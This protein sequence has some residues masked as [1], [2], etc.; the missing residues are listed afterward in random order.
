MNKVSKC[1][2]MLSGILMLVG[3]AEATQ[4]LDRG[5]GAEVTT[6]NQRGTLLEFEKIG[7]MTRKEIAASLVEAKIPGVPGQGVT[8]FRVSYAT[9][10][11]MG[12]ATIASG[13]IA[14]PEKLDDPAPILSFHHGTVVARN[15]VPS[16]QGFDLVSMGLGASGYITLLPDYL[17]LGIDTGFHPYVHAKSSGTVV[18]DMIRAASAFLDAHEVQTNGQLFLMGYSEGGYVTMAA[19]RE[20]E[21]YHED[22]IT[23]TASAP[24]A[25]PYN[26]STVMVQQILEDSAYPSP[27]YLPFT[28][29]AYDMV[30]DVFDELGDVILPEY[31]SVVESMMEGKTSLRQINRQLPPI[32][33]NM[34]TPAFIDAFQVDS[35]HPLRVALRENDVHNW[36]PRA[37]MRLYHCIDDDQVPFQNAEIALEA[38]ESHGA[39]HVE[40]AKLTFGDHND[41]APPALFLGKLWFDGF[42]DNNPDQVFQANVQIIRAGAY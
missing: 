37:P 16:V 30:Y 8:L 4:H 1:V 26:L 25:G 24:M 21:K 9:I 39:D 18:V 34:L 22:E 40:L 15:R 32:P 23:V 27:G 14:I 35:G 17:G 6:S 29:L 38:Y 42:V 12:Q 19:H 28:L 31:I 20:I 36:T 2:G 10:D 7:F 13:A 3:S 33:R 5:N 41:C 11:H